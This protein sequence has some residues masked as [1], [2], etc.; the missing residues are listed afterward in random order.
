MVEAIANFKKAEQILLNK[1]KIHDSDNFKRLINSINLV[2]VSKLTTIAAKKNNSQALEIIN[3]HLEDLSS[4]IANNAGVESIINNE[5]SLELSLN[6][7]DSQKN[8]FIDSCINE[9]KKLTSKVLICSTGNMGYSD[10]QTK[11]PAIA[12][13]LNKLNKQAVSEEARVDKMLYSLNDYYDKNYKDNYIKGPKAVFL[14]KAIDELTKAKT[15]VKNELKNN[16]IKVIEQNKSTAS[17]LPESKQNSSAAVTQ[18]IASPLI[19]PKTTSKTASM[20]R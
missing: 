18:E 9:Y 7:T 16:R 19:T 15:E 17:T 10:N 4:P 6:Y 11:Y 12:P 8:T 3:D 13:A 2:D 14:K 1:S 20:K 5:K